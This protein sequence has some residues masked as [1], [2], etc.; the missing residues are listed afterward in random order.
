LKGFFEVRGANFI[1]GKLRHYIVK[2]LPESYFNGERL[3]AYLDLLERIKSESLNGVYD[4][5]ERNP[6]IIVSHSNVPDET[7]DAVSDQTV[8]V[9][10]S[11]DVLP[12]VVSVDEDIDYQFELDFT[13]NSQSKT[14]VM[15]CNDRDVIRPYIKLQSE[16]MTADLPASTMLKVRNGAWSKYLMINKV[17]LLV[18]NR[19]KTKDE[20]RFGRE[21]FPVYSSERKYVWN[22]YL[23]SVGCSGG[24]VDLIRYDYDL[25]NSSI[26]FS[27]KDGYYVIRWDSRGV[28]LKIISQDGSL[29]LL[30]GSGNVIK[31]DKC[32]VGPQFILDAYYLDGIYYLVDINRDGCYYHFRYDNMLQIMEYVRRTG[33]CCR[34]VSYSRLDSDIYKPDYENGGLLFKDTRFGMSGGMIFGVQTFPI[35]LID[36]GIVYFAR[37]GKREAIGSSSV[38]CDGGY[39]RCRNLG[40]GTWFPEK[41]VYGYRSGCTRR[42][43]IVLSVSP[44]LRI[45]DLMNR[46]EKVKLGY[47]H[48]DHNSYQVCL[49][50]GRQ[51]CRS[52]GYLNTG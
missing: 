43:D 49:K 52:C 11:N 10:P 44:K 33:L 19:N 7:R 30:L 39:Y 47:L 36:N 22:S 45:G 26:E 41:Y 21:L 14:V 4:D 31:Y 13:A 27:G 6:V 35:L 9:T 29:Y 38:E 42:L 20:F 32:F 18:R 17:C 37:N 8:I 46:Y 48:V 3:K 23:Q 2:M 34:P 15:V 16:Y 5:V 40:N 1:K 25:E 50:C 24:D 28:R 51:G 12:V